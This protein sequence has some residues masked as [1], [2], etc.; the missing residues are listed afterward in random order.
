MECSSSQ[1]GVERLEACD[2]HT[3]K[4][5]LRTDQVRLWPGG[6]TL[7]WA[8]QQL[9]DRIPQRRRGFVEVLYRAGQ[10]SGTI[11]EEESALTRARE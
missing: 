7:S 3:W 8:M 5:E 9:A 6:D 1:K 2:D 10:S 11:L 4:V